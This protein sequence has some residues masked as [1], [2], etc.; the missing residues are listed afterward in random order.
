ISKEITALAGGG[1]LLVLIV[2]GIVIGRVRARRRKR[3]V[4]TALPIRVGDELDGQP[5]AAGLPGAAATLGLP[6]KG[7]RERALEAAPADTARAARIL[8][9]WL[10]EG[11]E[12]GRSA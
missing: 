8:S 10:G 6:G 4:L 12:G 7:A 11:A 3:E 1:L 2:A 9:A 5:Q